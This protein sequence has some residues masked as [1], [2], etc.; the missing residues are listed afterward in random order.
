MKKKISI[1][2]AAILFFLSAT[3]IFAEGEEEYRAI[4][5]AETVLSSSKYV[6]YGEGCVLGP[7]GILMG[8]LIRPSPP[9]TAVLGKS[10]EYAEEYLEDYNYRVGT[11]QAMAGV[12][13]CFTTAVVAATGGL[14]I[15]IVGALH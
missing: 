5:D 15:L 13:G 9:A 6:S 14:I 11:G 7:I 3:P 8:L 4:K 10:P 2:M 12:A 1:Y